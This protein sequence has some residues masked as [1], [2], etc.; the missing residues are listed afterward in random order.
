M[1]AERLVCRDGE[2]TSEQVFLTGERNAAVTERSASVAECLTS[3]HL[4]EVAF[5]AFG[6][7]F[8]VFL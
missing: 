5:S 6:W 7:G 8:W 3:F 4:L 2:D 1:R